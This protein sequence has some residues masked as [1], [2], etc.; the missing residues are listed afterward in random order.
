MGRRTDNGQGPAIVTW[1]GTPW[2][3]DQS[4]SRR[5]GSTAASASGTGIRIDRN[6]RIARAVTAG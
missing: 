5:N 3:L 1:A 4:P 6:R 2:A